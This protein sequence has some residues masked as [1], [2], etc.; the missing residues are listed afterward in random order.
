MSGRRRQWRAHDPAY[1]AMSQKKK[2]GIDKLSLQ[3]D[4]HIRGAPIVAPTSTDPGISTVEKRRIRKNELQNKKNQDKAKIKWKVLDSA[5]QAG[6]VSLAMRVATYGHKK[7]ILTNVY[8]LAAATATQLDD[9]EPECED[10]V[11][12]MQTDAMVPDRHRHHQIRQQK[13]VLRKAKE[14]EIGRLLGTS[15]PKAMYNLY[16]DPS[17]QHEFLAYID[18]CFE[19]SAFRGNPIFETYASPE[20]WTFMQH[21]VMTRTD[22]LHWATYAVEHFTAVATGALYE[23]K[24]QHVDTNMDDELEAAGHTPAAVRDGVGK[25]YIGANWRMVNVKTK[26]GDVIVLPVS[27]RSL[28][29]ASAGV[30]DVSRACDARENERMQGHCCGQQTPISSFREASFDDFARC[31]VLRPFL[32]RTALHIHPLS[33]MKYVGMVV[34]Y[35]VYKAEY[36]QINV[37]NLISDGF[38]RK[39]GGWSMLDTHMQTF[40][41]QLKR[42]RTLIDKNAREAGMHAM[43]VDELRALRPIRPFLEDLYEKMLETLTLASVLDESNAKYYDKYGRC[44]SRCKRHEAERWLRVCCNLNCRSPFIYGN[45]LN[46]GNAKRDAKCLACKNN[47]QRSSQYVGVSWDKTRYQWAATI[48]V[49]RKFQHLGRFGC[50]DDAT[51]AYDVVARAANR[52]TNL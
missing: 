32:K 29:A 43:S 39:A 27:Q 52:R 40:E 33:G 12:T 34:H 7:G 23:Y 18:L 35:L 24:L 14:V 46:Y 48:T 38:N 41:L 2:G 51:R 10:D 42:R 28:L 36:E 15:D 26:T 20:M 4:V 31:P 3:Y 49:N 1:I 5:Y 8:P 37:R 47:H 17:F 11:T 9:A 45:G 19:S 22:N 30:R 16:S 21:F 13:V 44:T 6:G 50:E 25:S